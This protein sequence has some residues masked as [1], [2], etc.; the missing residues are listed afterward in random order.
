MG[1]SRVEKTRKKS[2]AAHVS[3]EDPEQAFSEPMAD[4]IAH[5][6]QEHGPTQF[7]I[8]VQASLSC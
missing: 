7:F 3:Q 4:R 5:W 6:V 8:Q 1:V 2:Q